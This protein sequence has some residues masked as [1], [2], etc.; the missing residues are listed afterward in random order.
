MLG[1]QKMFSKSD[2]VNNTRTIDEGVSPEDQQR[3]YDAFKISR[4]TRI[5]NLLIHETTLKGM[6]EP[7]YAD[8]LVSFAEEQA[9]TLT[10]DFNNEVAAQRE[11]EAIAELDLIQNDKTARKKA[12]ENDLDKLRADGEIDFRYSDLG[13]DQIEEL[14][15][16]LADN[17]VITGSEANSQYEESQK[18]E[19][20][21]AIN[22]SKNL[23]D[24]AFDKV[25]QTGRESGLY[26]DFTKLSEEDQFAIMD[27]IS[28]NS[29]DTPLDPEL[30]GEAHTRA[31]EADA[32]EKGE[33]AAKEEKTRLD[34]ITKS[35][36]DSISRGE[37][38]FQLQGLG[39]SEEY[40]QFLREGGTLDQLE[41]QLQTIIR[42]LPPGTDITADI[43][44]LIRDA[45]SEPEVAPPEA[46]DIEMGTQRGLSAFDEA[47][48]VEER[49][50]QPLAPSMPAFETES[51]FKARIAREAAQID[52]T[53]IPGIPASA[54]RALVSAGIAPLPTLG[55]AGTIT[56]EELFGMD[57][58]TDTEL[59]QAALDLSGGDPF[60]QEYLINQAGTKSFD[61]RFRSESQRRYQE[62]EDIFQARFGEVVDTSTGKV[63]PAR[64]Q[65][66][67]RGPSHAGL[68]KTDFL[69][70]ESDALTSQFDVQPSTVQRRQNE[71]ESARMESENE[72]ERDREERDRR[73]LRG[74]F[75][76]FSRR[77]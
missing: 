24:L 40:Q 32:I 31:L 39:G 51:Q 62:A 57:F 14:G 66:T 61:E 64:E 9:A 60:L 26:I 70:Q 41:F 20:D 12:V 47:L 5:R 11:A 6:V 56:Q 46:G 17:K 45:L 33:V 38:E 16:I 8:A 74:G 76:T 1:G 28:T 34:A 42:D 52:P 63:T 55:S 73:A 27:F 71:E 68:S 36:L 67:A 58:G 3:Q 18:A 30:V 13:P 44:G 21:A 37:L 69:A 77:A 48:N 43:P 29:Y 50:R 4:D 2:F 19:H 15:K 75:S 25:F 10:E 22:D 53:R 7:E 49:A 54:Q 23:E 59:A 72:A 65:T 35:N